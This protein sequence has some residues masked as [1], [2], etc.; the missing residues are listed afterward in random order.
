MV[1]DLYSWK[2]SVQIIH[3]I[4][5][6]L[7]KVR[8]VKLL[9]SLSQPPLHSSLHCSDDSTRSLVIRFVFMSPLPSWMYVLNPNTC[10]LGDFSLV[11]SILEI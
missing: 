4:L 10:S 6:M 5:Q 1:I 3:F 8:E 2:F 11:I 9:P 7:P